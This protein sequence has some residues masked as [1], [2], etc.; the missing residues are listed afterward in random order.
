MG[1]KITAWDLQI[2]ESSTFNGQMWKKPANDSLM[3]RFKAL[4]S[5]ISECFNLYGS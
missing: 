3:T 1:I 5:A 2:S 4:I